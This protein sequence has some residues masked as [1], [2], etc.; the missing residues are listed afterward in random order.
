MMKSHN[1]CIILGLL[2]LAGCWA[3]VATENSRLA[4]LLTPYAVAIWLF[5]GVVGL[6]LLGYGVMKFF[7]S[8]KRPD[9]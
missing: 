9:Q 2:L 7:D 6:A 3:S 4:I 1:I 5:G 8:L